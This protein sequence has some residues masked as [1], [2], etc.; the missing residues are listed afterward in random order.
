MADLE[1]RAAGLDLEGSSGVLLRRESLTSE[2]PV[3]SKLEDTTQIPLA[4]GGKP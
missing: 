4:R 1:C 3:D 2:A